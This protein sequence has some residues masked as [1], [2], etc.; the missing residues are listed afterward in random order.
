MS[1]FK[2]MANAVIKGDEKAC[3]ELANQVIKE[4]VNPLEAIQE[5]FAKGMETVGQNFEAGKFYLPEMM[6]AAKAMNAGVD[7]LEPV[8]A[9]KNLGSIQGKGKWYL[10]PSRVICMISGKIFSN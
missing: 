9:A 10:R 4:E 6:L 8:I 7:I 1:I 3:T 5:G 2:E